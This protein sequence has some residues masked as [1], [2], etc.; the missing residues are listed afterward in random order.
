METCSKPCGVS[1]LLGEYFVFSPPYPTPEG[2]CYNR[3]W[4]AGSTCVSVIIWALQRSTLKADMFF[5]SSFVCHWSLVGFF[6]DSQ[7]IRVHLSLHPMFIVTAL[8]SIEF[9][10]K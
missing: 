10:I 5:Y 4:E 9:V 2:G 3:A 1:G 7:R 6:R 8:L